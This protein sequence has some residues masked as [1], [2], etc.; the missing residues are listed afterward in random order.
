MFLFGRR[1]NKKEKRKIP[2]TVQQSIPIDRLYKDGVFKC[3]NT[4]SKTWRFSDINYAV[5]SDDDQLSLFLAH[6]ALI[7]GLPTDAMAK[8]TIF[9][10]QLSKDVL[11]NL[12]TPNGEKNYALYARE[13]GEIFA[14][15]MADSNNIV[16]DKFIT[17]S[18]EKK[19][20]EES[21]TFFTRVGNDLTADFAKLSSKTTELG[22][23][24]RLR[25]FYDFFRNGDMGEFEFDMKKAIAKGKHFKDKICPDSI[26]FKSDH[27]RLGEKYARV[28]FLKEYPSF[29]KDSMLSELTDFSR[30]MML[31]VD[32]QPIPTDDAVKQVQKKL[33]AI[34]TDITKWQQKQ[35]MNNNFSANIPYEMEQMRK[36][37]KEFLDDITTRDQRMMFVTVTLVHV[38]DTLDELNNDTETLLSIGRKHLCTFGILKYQQEDGFNTVLPYGL[39]QIKAIRTLTTE[40]TAVLMPYKTQEII[41]NN[42]LYY[43][44]NAISHNLLMCNRKLLLNGNGFIL[45]VSGSGKSFASKLEIAL[46]SIFTNDDIIIIDPE[47]EYSPLVL[48]LGG[49]SVRMSASD[50]SA[51]HINAMAINKDV[52]DENPVSMK[53]E[54][55]ISIFDELLKS[56]NSRMG[57]GVGA[58]D[59]SIIDRCTIRVYADYMNGRTDKEPTLM[60]LRDELL[61]QPEPEAHDLALCLE[62]FT[63]GSLNS[64]AHQSNV[65]VN[66]RIVSYDIL[67]L[68]EQMKSIGLLIMLDNIMNRVIENRKKGKYTRVYIDEAHLFFKNEYSADFLLKAWKRFR[69][70]G[71]LLTGITQ[72]I[73]DCLKNDTARGMLSNS[74]FLLMLNQAPTDRIELA[75]LLNISDTQM[76]YITNAG[77]GRGLIKVGGSIVPFVNDFPSDTEL[78]KLM[79]TKPGQG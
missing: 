69:K 35:N 30:S 46:A 74:E 59:K 27:I 37:I 8:I 5:A 45:G 26:E 61:N 79:S 9:N 56:G 36:E 44:I 57:G 16:H 38:A 41:D 60:Q 62:M 77:A 17:I 53:S 43:G 49:V 19:N 28:I 64:F 32:I 1:K 21:R 71:G 31:S 13:L 12:A 25:I 22:Y 67:E 4:Y 29:L 58:K 52:E 40:S 55:L 73:E 72:N 75:K 24:D 2:K 68:G 76:S 54:L 20:I 34:E 3:G 11:S 47:R 39:M 50:S 65:D 48:N 70:Y 63:T 78:F 18:S 33:L 14:D 51:N 6:S 7:N 15:K 66:S 10:R 42:G 23:K